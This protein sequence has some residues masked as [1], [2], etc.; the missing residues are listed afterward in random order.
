MRYFLTRKLSL[1]LHDKPDPIG[2]A[3]AK[4]IPFFK[5]QLGNPQATKKVAQRPPLFDP[6]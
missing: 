4:I 3:L 2:G 5:E 1:R 6:A